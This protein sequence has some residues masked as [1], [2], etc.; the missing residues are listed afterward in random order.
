[1]NL[2]IIV[3]LLHSN[4]DKDEVEYY[5]ADA[6]EK[7]T[8]GI[9]SLNPDILNEPGLIVMVADMKN[10]TGDCYLWGMEPE[11]VTFLQQNVSQWSL[12]KVF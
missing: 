8:N 6:I 2:E 10:N 3:R 11:T 5:N 4:L 7:V 1:M 12:K 9:K